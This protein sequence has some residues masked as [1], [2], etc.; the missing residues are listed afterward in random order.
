MRIALLGPWPP[1]FG[2]VST[3]L[4]RLTYGLEQRG[5]TVDV[6]TGRERVRGGCR[7]HAGA[8][9]KVGWYLRQ[10]TDRGAD[11]IH[12]H[13]VAGNLG[14]LARLA[15]LA[16]V[17]RPLLLTLHS[18]R[19]H[20]E[21]E[22]IRGH[23]RLRRLLAPFTHIICVGAEVRDALIGI[24]V[25]PSR[26]SVVSPYL[27]PPRAI[28][29]PQLPAAL[30]VF[31]AAHAPVLTANASDLALHRGVDL[32]G[33]DLCVEL[34]DKL[35]ADFPRVGLVFVIAGCSDEA[36]LARMRDRI[37]AL[38]LTRDL[39]VHRSEE[40]YWPVIARSDLLVRATASDSF[41]ISVAEALDL[42]I[43]AV[44]SDVCARPPGTVLFHNRDSIDLVRQ[45]WR[46][47]RDGPPEAP[48]P[49]EAARTLEEIL[50]LYAGLVRAQPHAEDATM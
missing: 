37:A 28:E 22:T 17:G 48:T 32:Y 11:V 41:G 31:F 50:A 2:G 20:P 43:P 19:P 13:A 38:G 29:P 3:H 23:R 46:V 21:D 1:P 18:F 14:F 33:M 34:L 4:Q 24:G 42:G 25:S 44:A 45:V 30:E 35:R 9:V 12:A 8:F 36:H 47:L 39:L 6:W 5:V 10:L 49:P 15:P 16:H 26:A 40:E 7:T 27:P